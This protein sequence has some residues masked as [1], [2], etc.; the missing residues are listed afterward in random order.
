MLKAFVSVGLTPLSFVSRHRGGE[1][2]TERARL[3][4]TTRLLQGELWHWIPGNWLHSLFFFF[5]L[6]FPLIYSFLS[7]LPPAQGGF[8]FQ[9]CTLPELTVKCLQIYI[10]AYTAVCAWRGG[11]QSCV[12]RSLSL[13]A[14]RRPAEIRL[15]LVKAGTNLAVDKATRWEGF[16][17]VIFGE[18]QHS[19]RSVHWSGSFALQIS[20]SVHGK[21]AIR[22]LFV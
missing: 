12:P 6:H 1:E 18:L 5:Y 21:I 4:Q 10:M 3:P 16:P 17:F 22:G 15:P 7:Y 2:R 20:I 19:P 14:D 8:K 9:S 13:K 11:P